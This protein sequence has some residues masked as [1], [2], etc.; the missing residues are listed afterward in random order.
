MKMAY[1]E[2]TIYT[3]FLCKKSLTT[4]PCYYCVWIWRLYKALMLL[5][6]MDLAFVQ[7]VNVQYIKY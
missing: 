1:N 6:C 2:M 3:I 5:L 4:L 7:S